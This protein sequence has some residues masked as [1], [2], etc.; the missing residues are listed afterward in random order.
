[1][2]LE[3]L[4]S[5]AKEAE[6]NPEKL[7]LGRCERGETAFHMAADEEHLD[8]LQ[9]LRAWAVEAPLNSDE[10]KNKLLISKDIFGFTAWHGSAARGNLE[11]L[12]L[13]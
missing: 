5:W 8:V 7:L 2:A 10:L 9:K 11:A 13:L 4:W 6:I 1:V 3:I 12:K